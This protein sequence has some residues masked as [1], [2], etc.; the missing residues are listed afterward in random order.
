MSPLE[1]PEV[2]E[3]AGKV[4]ADMARQMAKP[5]QLPPIQGQRPPY[6]QQIDVRRAA[7]AE[8][9][10]AQQLRQLQAQ[11]Q[12]ALNGRGPTVDAANIVQR[13]LNRQQ[14]SA[15]VAVGSAA[16]I[17]HLVPNA[18]PGEQ[19]YSVGELHQPPNEG[20]FSREYY[21]QQSTS[22]WAGRI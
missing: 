12:L 5:S 10:R 16:G 1:D 9:H 4:A 11:Q 19:T 20:I 22:P 8:E 18:M 15:A 2:I 21:S 3:V 17:V 14:H 6:S 7:L 13:L